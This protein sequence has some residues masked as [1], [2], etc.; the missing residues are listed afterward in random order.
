MT[1]SSTRP[2]MAA[3][4]HDTPNHVPSS[5]GYGAGSQ[6]QGNTNGDQVIN[7]TTGNK[8]SICLGPCNVNLDG[9]TLKVD[10]LECG[11]CGGWM[12][13]NCLPYNKTE[14]RMLAKPEIHWKCPSCSQNPKANQSHYQVSL[15]RLDSIEKK[16]DQPLDLF[17]KSLVGITSALDRK[18]DRS[19]TEIGA[20]PTTN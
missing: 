8:P 12:C 14:K 17:N 11:N 9:T 7:A 3:M 6:A 10:M 13:F 20:E 2:K 16:L 5:Q 1:A 4:N 18:A 15:P 19:E